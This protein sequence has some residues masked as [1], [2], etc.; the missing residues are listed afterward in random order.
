MHSD[1]SA[2]G[3]G[4]GL[5]ADGAG[6]WPGSRVGLATEA[7]RREAAC[8][9]LLMTHLSL[10]GAAARHQQAAAAYGAGL[11]LHGCCC[12]PLCPL[13]RVACNRVLNEVLAAP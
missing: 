1:G 6:A 9:G 2:R 12:S 13:Q 8:Q 3:I 5:R 10:D 11:A 7:D 4:L